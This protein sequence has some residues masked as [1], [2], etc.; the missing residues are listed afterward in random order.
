MYPGGQQR[1]KCAETIAVDLVGLVVKRANG[2]FTA[3]D[4]IAL[5]WISSRCELCR[6]CPSA[7][8]RLQLMKPPAPTPTLADPPNVAVLVRRAG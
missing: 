1:I 4:Q 5:N 2:S 7:L 3:R 6:A 8:A